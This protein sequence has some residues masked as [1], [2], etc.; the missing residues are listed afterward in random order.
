MSFI[1]CTNHVFNIL[2]LVLSVGSN[3][4][5]LRDYQVHDRPV[6]C[7]SFCTWDS[8]KLFSTSHDGSV[9]CGDIIKRTFDIVSIKSFILF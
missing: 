1:I 4:M 6:N 8:Y 5:E 9:R 3:Q 7:I 2:A